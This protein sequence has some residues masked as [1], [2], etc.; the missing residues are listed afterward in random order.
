[1]NI[2]FLNSHLQFFFILHLAIHTQIARYMKQFEIINCELF[3]F[4]NPVLILDRSNLIL[5]II[6]KKKCTYNLLYIIFGSIIY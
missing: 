2:R 5:Q 1:M 3:K 6:F 4:G